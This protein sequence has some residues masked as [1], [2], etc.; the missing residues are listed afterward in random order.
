[1]ASLRQAFS[2]RNVRYRTDDVGIRS[3]GLCSQ[4]PENFPDL[5]Q[6]THVSGIIASERPDGKPE[7]KFM[8]LLG[9]LLSQIL[10]PTRPRRCTLVSVNV[11]SSNEDAV[12]K[13]S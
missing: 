5:Y 8:Y 11:T 13:C 6:T 9:D 4:E 3:V 7:S 2:W 10:V 12:Q 1:M